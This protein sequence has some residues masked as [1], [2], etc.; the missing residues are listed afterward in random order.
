MAKFTGKNGEFQVLTVASP[1]TWV[2]VG[3]V[4]EIGSASIT[5]EEIDTT[6]LD[7]NQSGTST[8]YKDFL[9][10]FKDPGEMSLVVLF[11]PNLASHGSLTNGLF[12]LFDS[13][14]TVTARVKYPTSPTTYLTMSGFFRDWETPTINATDPIESTFTF[15]LRQK[16]TLGTT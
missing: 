6:T 15:R 4:R 1:A 14:R 3:Q 16:P 2:A 12:E 7:S 11:D 5:S 10:G 9:P 13:G 8:D